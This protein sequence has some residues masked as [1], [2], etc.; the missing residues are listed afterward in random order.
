M[1]LGELIIL[2]GIGGLIAGLVV[3]VVFLAKRGNRPPS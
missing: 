1:G 3:L 2:V